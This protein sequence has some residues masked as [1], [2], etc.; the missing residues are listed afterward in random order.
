ME[1]IPEKYRNH[2][3]FQRYFDLWQK[4]ESSFVFVPLADMLRSEDLLE[5]AREVCERGL[6][7]HPDSVSGRLILA[8]VY[9]NLGRKE[10]ADGIARQILERMPSHPEA[11]KFLLHDP[12]GSEATSDQRERE[13]E[14]PPALPAE[15]VTR[16]PIMMQTLTMAKI[17]A[18]QGAFT[19][20]RTIVQMLLQ[21]DPDNGQLIKC[22][23][24]WQQH[25]AN[26]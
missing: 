18:E 12:L 24:E 2:P 14:A 23:Q 26:V 5:E 15:G 6:Q 17:L 20:A 3:A 13:G 25:K 21:Q 10:E 19:E 11:Q 7:H 8:K 1:Q 4:D 16:T 22:L 9:W